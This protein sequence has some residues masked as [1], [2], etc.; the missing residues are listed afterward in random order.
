MS[1]YSIWLIDR[2]LSGAATSDQSGP[3]RDGN[4]NVLHIPQSSRTGTSLSDAFESYQNTCWRGMRQLFCRDAVG[5]FYSPNRMYSDFLVNFHVRMVN[6]PFLIIPLHLYP[7]SIYAMKI[8]FYILLVPRF[9][10]IQSQIC[11]RLEIWLNL[12]S[13]LPIINV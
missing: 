9:L 10:I 4:E 6:R 12:L 2:T 8:N 7:L 1:N 3:G 5:V 13:S 11:I